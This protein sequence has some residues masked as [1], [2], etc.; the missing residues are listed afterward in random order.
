MSLVQFS[1]AVFKLS[2]RSFSVNSSVSLAMVKAKKFVYATPFVGEPK[3]TDFQLVEEEL[4][5][6][7]ENGKY[8]PQ[9]LVLSLNFRILPRNPGGSRIPQR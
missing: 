8:F 7:Q 1:R 9:N 4:P 6:L 2:K 5:E 3:V